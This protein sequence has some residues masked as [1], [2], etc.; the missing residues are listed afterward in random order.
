DLGAI[1]GDV[2][3]RAKLMWL[4]YPNNPTSAL[5]TLEFYKQVAAFALE[6]GIVV[7][8]DLAY[9]EIYY[10]T[11]PPPS[12]LPAPGGREGGIQVPSLSKTFNMTGWRVGFAV[13]NAALI[14]G[15]GKVKTNTDSGTFGAIQMAGIEA[16]SSDQACV[17]ELRATYAARADVL[18][19]GLSGAGL[20]V[21]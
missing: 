9:S 6:H 11:E 19:D 7:A 15:L 4:N 16:L 1:P 14:A 18:C 17:T 2:A 20:D 3:R 10:H 5:A 13:G 8:S 12:F 21:I